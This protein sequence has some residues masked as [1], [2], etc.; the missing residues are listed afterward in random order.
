VRKLLIGLVLTAL[1][2]SAATAVA[3]PAPVASAGLPLPTADPFYHYSG[4]LPGVAPGTVLRSRQMSTPLP[5]TATQVLY[6]TTDQLQRPS[7]TAALVVRPNGAS[8]TPRIVSYQEAYDSLGA[9]CDP[10]YTAVNGTL[11]QSDQAPMAAAL[12]AGYTVVTADYEGE[13]LDYGAG[14]ESGYGT[15][16]GIRAAEN[17]VKADPAATPAAMIGFS[18]GGIATEFATEL[19]AA[20]APDLHIVGAVEGGLP[21]DF[22]HTIDYIDGSPDWSKVLPLVLTGASR[23]FHIDFTPYL[24]PFGIQI[25]SKV[26]SVGV[27]NAD[28]NAL[29]VIRTR[30]LLKPE[31]A[32]YHKIRPLVD[33]SNKLI[34]GTSGTPRFPIMIGIGNSDG[35]GDGV[36]IAKDEQALAHSYC[37]R[38]VPVDFHEFPGAD[39]FVAG[40]L[41]LAAGLPYLAQRFA[42][43]PAPDNCATVPQGNSLAPAT[44]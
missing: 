33:I 14:Q 20:Y 9:Q 3:A 25:M 29:P 23:G 43:A 32:D 31:Y 7:V 42:G 37:G 41:T 30:D 18:G 28:Q 15:L 17:L 5:G 24:N 2:A 11:G 39:H 6:R 22:L 34:M 44:V 12:A 21:V 4:S 1:S 13:T 27:C 26:R 36:M 19:A 10:S 35:T 38:G 16:D 40:G 8:G